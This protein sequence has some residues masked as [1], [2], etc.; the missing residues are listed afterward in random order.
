MAP[1]D[2]ASHRA[3][4]AG[5]VR[6]IRPPTCGILVG[7]SA[8]GN[9]SQSAGRRAE[10]WSCS[11]E[12]ASPAMG[13]QKVRLAAGE[14]GGPWAHFSMRILGTLRSTHN[15]EQRAAPWTCPTQPFG[16]CQLKF[17]GSRPVSRAQL[18]LSPLPSHQIPV[19]P[20]Q[21][22][23]LDKEPPSS[24]RRENAVQSRENRSIHWSRAGRATWRRRANS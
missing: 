3:G 14:L 15:R 16:S 11:R 12:Q 18:S 1:H 24:S 17:G 23:R 9:R 13:P 22:L 10:R 20:K 19:S 7:G 4:L 2:R 21:G 8:Y 5:H 6:K